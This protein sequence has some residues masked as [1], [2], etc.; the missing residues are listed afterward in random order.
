ML[1]TTVGC[2]VQ[3]LPTVLHDNFP[4]IHP[5]YIIENIEYLNVIFNFKLYYDDYLACTHAHNTYK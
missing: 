4:T 2:T 1:L 3:Y 5:L